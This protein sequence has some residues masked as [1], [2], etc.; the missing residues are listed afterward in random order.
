[1]SSCKGTLGGHRR[2]SV[3]TVLEKHVL[4]V[5]VFIINIIACLKQLNVCK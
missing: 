2:I 3:L 4:G 5:P 1:M